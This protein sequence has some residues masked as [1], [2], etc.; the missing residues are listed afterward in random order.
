MALLELPGVLDV[1]IDES[2]VFQMKTG[3]SLDVDAAKKLL[4]EKKVEVKDHDT[5]DG[6]RFG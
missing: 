1:L 2:I 4:E 6:Y 3:E 5:I